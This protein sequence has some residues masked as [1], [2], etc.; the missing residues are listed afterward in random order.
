MDRKD[1]IIDSMI[2]EI[3]R[4]MES[5]K[6]KKD[7]ESDKITVSMTGKKLGFLE[8]MSTKSLIKSYNNTI[9]MLND[10][11]VQL[12]YLNTVEINNLSVS[13]DIIKGFNEL[14]AYLEPNE[15]KKM[16]ELLSSALKNKN[17]EIKGTIENKEKIIEKNLKG[18][19]ILQA[20]FPL[21]TFSNNI[22][23][24]TDDMVSFEKSMQ[25]VG[26]EFSKLLKPQNLFLNPTKREEN[27]LL[28]S[29]DLKFI[30]ELQKAYTGK[31]LKPDKS[32][33]NI[34]S[35][36]QEIKSNYES[37]DQIKKNILCIDDL[38]RMIKESP[39]L[40]FEQVASELNSIKKK[41]Q[42]E[43]KK[44][45]DYIA[46]FDFTSSRMKIAEIRKEEK[47]EFSSSQNFKTYRNLAYELEKTMAE[48]PN[49]FKKANDIKA[50][51]RQ[52]SQDGALDEFA[53]STALNEAKEK[54]Y[55]D[56][57][58]ARLMRENKAEEMQETK[59]AHSLAMQNLREAALKELDY[60]E[61]FEFRNG[62]AYSSG[63][64]REEAIQRKMEE[65]KALASLSPEERGLQE[66][67]KKGKLAPDV[68]LKD[69]SYTQINDFRIA[70]SDSALGLSEYKK[71]AAEEARKANPI[72]KE[73]I[74]Y[75]ASLKDKSNYMTFAN[76]A[77][78]KYHTM[79][80][81]EFVSQD[82]Q[83]KLQEENIE[84]VS[85]K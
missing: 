28:I 14:A 43:L 42:N 65:L 69:L 16:N 55:N 50:Q 53:I 7:K 54:Y 70:Y 30:N 58:N 34:M 72:Y 5:V 62:D 59:E 75:R 1:Q 80:N 20:K 49:D 10:I 78:E 2:V 38:L 27:E 26:G 66:L 79:V 4:R 76:F 63:Q 52:V 48:S 18:L 24:L 41:Y 15:V 19:G 31:N 81:E 61:S 44:A 35:H 9:E 37:I 56:V 6:E 17:S 33:D 21:Y 84:G 25:V 73:Y 67:K 45:E 32:I 22:K 39:D 71:Y 57:N 74:L 23:N 51:M 68:T 46:K 82:L 40:P 29:E 85:R 60:E 47:K 64:S 3:E 8:K 83:N 36:F 11:R 13:E 12:S 77:K